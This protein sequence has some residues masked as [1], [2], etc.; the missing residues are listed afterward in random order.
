[1]NNFTLYSL[2]KNPVLKKL[3]LLLLLPLSL[4]AQKDASFWFAA[5][6]VNQFLAGNPH[7][8]P[9]LLRLTSFSSPSTV[10]ISIPAN[11]S[12][13][14]LT[15]TIAANSSGIVD[16]SA[17]ADQIENATA[18]TVA[19]KGILIRATADIT[20]YYE[21]VSNCNC[22]PELFSLKGKN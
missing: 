3:L 8:R 19:N 16:L 6:D 7:D 17:W 14:P 4:F 9:I 21:I 1:M 18:N 10:T 20:A 12:F 22:N 11:P 2:T 13:T 5:P 15:N